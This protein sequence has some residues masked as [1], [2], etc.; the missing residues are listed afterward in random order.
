MRIAI[1]AAKFTSDE[2]NGLRRAMATFRHVG[3]IGTFEKKMVDKMIERGYP[4]DFARNCFEQIKGFGEYGFPE[5][6]AAGFAKLV[7]VSAWLKCHHP[8]V[9]ACGLLNSQP[10]GSSPAQIIRDAR[11]N[12]VVVRGVDVS[13][14]LPTTPSRRSAGRITPCGSA[15]ARSTASFMPT[16]TTRTMTTTARSRNSPSTGRRRSSPRANGSR[17][18]RSNSSR[19]SP[20]CQRRRSFCSPR[21]MPSSRWV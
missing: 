17:S 19:I 2:A 7:Y 9:F 6:H 13:L 18:H 8:D 16:P 11:K 4:P 3:T 10:M 12:E 14:A 5:S 21:P 20:G 15:S 1:E